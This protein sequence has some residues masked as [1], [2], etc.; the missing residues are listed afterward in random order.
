M[1]YELTA[2]LRLIDMLTAPMRK[3]E[4]QVQSTER[5]TR[6]YSEATTKLSDSHGKLARSAGQSSTQV[7]S[8][9][10]RLSK[11][12]SSAG[13]SISK[14][15]KTAAAFSALGVAAAGV[16][17][18]G[19][20]FGGFK[21]AM[22]YEAQLSSIQA[23][24]GASAEEMKLMNALALEMGAK[25]KYSALQAAQ[26]IEELLK[27]GLSPATVK[28]GGLEAALNLA[29][30]GGLD[31][32][33]AAEIMSTSLNAF[34][35]DGLKASQA[36]DYLAGTANA[37]AT[38][39]HDLKYSLSA[40]GAVAAGV[41]LSLKDTT[42]A[43]GVLA[44]K[45]LK[46]SDAG[47]SLKT[48]LMRLQPSSKEQIEMFKKL[49]IVTK[50]GG[51]KFFTAKGKIQSF[52]KIAGV[53]HEAL[54]GMTDMQRSAAL[55]VMFGSDA[56][57]A[58][59][60]IYD[61]GA[62]GVKNFQEEMS[63]V[64]ALDVAKKKMDNA[65]GAV[66]QFR[67]AMETLQI[68]ALMPTLPIFKKLALAAADFVGKYTPQITAGI[69]RMVNKAK[70]FVKD[71]FINN[72]EFNSLP[73]LRQ[74]F[75]FV[76]QSLKDTFNK[77]YASGGQEQI[78]GT[79]KAL[80]SYMSSAVK[81]SYEP[82]KQIGMDIGKPMAA[83]ML[84]GLKDFAKSNPE[85]AALM[86]FLMTPGPIQVKT[87]AA[88]ATGAGGIGVAESV[89]G[90]ASNLYQEVSSD[91][92]KFDNGFMSG[93]SGMWDRAKQN[94][95]PLLNPPRDE[96]G[97]V[98]VGAERVKYEKANG[99]HAGGLARVPYDG[100]VARLHKD[101]RVLTKDQ[102]R[103][104]NEGSSASG[105]GNV[106]VTGNTFIVRQESDIDTIAASI[107]RQAWDIR[108]GVAAQ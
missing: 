22:D 87:A 27:A 105:G 43:L 98:I 10:K 35:K 16:V 64:T 20:A 80:V 72:P 23:L 42:S 21:R 74:K 97:R 102:N 71:R 66:E 54:K 34:S 38:D 83:G 77:W 91:F 51:N 32:A 81:A 82:I 52:E 104:Y 41:G 46:G 37:S 86:A 50:D 55:E 30:A 63:K 67:G 39:V 6:A 107:A 8:V 61:T 29:T 103:A 24:T 60:I 99:S 96:N 94:L 78:N 65:A 84:D 108:G 40:V 2:K 13:D 12:S 106:T 44:N 9:N 47:T 57:R 1:A 11:M 62:D 33:E 58:A 48:M 36:A 95:E 59:T 69:E 76:I 89:V 26:G 25:T 4:R 28:A 31:L 5:A 17:A 56:V 68:S 70:T 14:I 93:L 100:Y 45:A 92:G 79:I 18:G 15:G 101:E 53:L 85:A 49:G 73:T 19:L 7:D 88:L 75:E 90:S 3:V